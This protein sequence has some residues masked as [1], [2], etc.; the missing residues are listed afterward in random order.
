MLYRAQLG[1]SLPVAGDDEGF[2]SR[3]RID[4]LSVVVAQLSLGQE[5]GHAKIVAEWATTCYR[6]LLPLS[7]KTF[8]RRTG[9]AASSACCRRRTREDRAAAVLPPQRPA[10]DTQGPASR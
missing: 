9:P 7:V 1:H 6:G 2:A 10:G 4:H 3:D 8:T 5:L